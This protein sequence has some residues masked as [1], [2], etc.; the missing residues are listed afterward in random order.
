MKDLELNSDEYW[1]SL[2]L[3]LA[4]QGIFS[5]APNPRVGAII[6]DE[7]NN[8]L[9]GGFHPQAGEAHAEIF[10]LKQAGKKAK[11]ATLFVNLEPC[12]HTGRTPPCVDA[13]IKAGIS[14]VVIANKDPNPL[15]SGKGV[16]ALRKAGI[17]VRTG[18]LK[19]EGEK[20][21]Q[22]FFK[23][24][25]TGLPFISLKMAAS[26]D[27]KTALKN[28]KSQW[29]TGN[30]AR[31]N[32]HFH[33]LQA[34]AILC[35]SG[36]IINDD[37]RLSARFPTAL[38]QIQPLKVVVDSQ[39]KTP[40]NATIFKDNVPVIIATTEKKILKSYPSNTE[41]IC[42]EPNNEGKVPLR[43][44]IEILANKGINNLFIEAGASLAGAF[45]KENLVDEM[46]LYL[47]PCFLGQD[48]RG[49]INIAE[50]FNLEDRIA[51]KITDIKSFNPDIR[52]TINF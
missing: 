17:A 33:R 25:I 42:F 4:R 16:A 40:E 9:G 27:G 13:I 21:N 48:A 46:F 24:M 11:G 52:L 19:E 34:D 43:S 22:G 1:L 30:N 51:G 39:L 31:K 49:L 7:E 3:N 6:V 28:G 32:V 45:F 5:T 50:L 14:R 47:A 44:L 18:V 37:A 23:R 12:S 41:I 20:L 36:S 26:L 2:A 10:A 38:P 35:G 8:F 15:V 29:I